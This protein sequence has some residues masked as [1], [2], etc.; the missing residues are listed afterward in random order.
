MTYLARLFR[1]LDVSRDQHWCLNIAIQFNRINIEDVFLS[2]ETMNL[3][4]WNVLKIQMH[5]LES[6]DLDLDLD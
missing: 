1:P 2:A 6:R 4:R 3:R 5:D